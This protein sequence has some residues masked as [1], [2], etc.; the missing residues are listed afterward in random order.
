MAC[1]GHC[2]HC[3]GHSGYIGPG[4]AATWTND[5]IGTLDDV[6]AVDFN[7]LRTQWRAEDTRWLVSIPAGDPGAVDTNTTVYH[8]HYRWLVDCLDKITAGLDRTYLTD[9]VL[10]TGH[11]I[12]DESTEAL[13][14]HLN[15]LR[16]L[17]VC[18]CNYACTCNCNYCVCNCNYACVCNCNNYSDKELKE[19]IK[20]L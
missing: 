2:N 15:Y 14:T 4:V 18:N 7:E 6:G 16:S 20:Y 3:P 11:Q 9:A 5:P 10:I 1:G 8:T 19:N 13:R 12:Q 17:C